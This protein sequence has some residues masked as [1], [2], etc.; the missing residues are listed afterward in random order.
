MLHARLFVESEKYRDGHFE[1][2]KAPLRTE[3]E[4]KAEAAKRAKRQGQE[5][6]VQPGSVPEKSA[7]HLDGN[8]AIDRPLFVQF[9]AVL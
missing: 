7:P 1:P 8:P 6:E 4:A 3:A 2:T 9:C 5:S